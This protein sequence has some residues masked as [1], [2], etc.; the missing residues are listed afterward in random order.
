MKT[1]WLSSFFKEL[2]QTL[3]RRPVS[4]RGAWRTCKSCVLTWI[5]IL[6]QLNGAEI[7]G[8]Q[9]SLPPVSSCPCFLCPC[10]LHPAW[11]ALAC[12][13][14]PVSLT[15]F[16]HLASALINDGSL[17]EIVRVDLENILSRLPK[18]YFSPCTI[19]MELSVSLCS[20][21]S[22]KTRHSWFSL[23][24]LIGG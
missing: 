24:M 1:L 22:H 6:W 17:T 11:P 19:F 18:Q 7:I 14:H 12:S 13:L 9:Q 8:S 10:S 21:F 2:L 5:G 15:L 4:Q 23:F 16:L 20:E 3:P